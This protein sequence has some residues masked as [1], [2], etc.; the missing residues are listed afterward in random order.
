MFMLFSI[1][2]FVVIKET[3]NSNSSQAH[4]VHFSYVTWNTTIY[5]RYRLSSDQQLLPNWLMALM[6]RYVCLLSSNSW[7][8]RLNPKLPRRQTHDILTK[9]SQRRPSLLHRPGKVATKHTLTCSM[10]CVTF[11][12][13]HKTSQIITMSIFHSSVIEGDIKVDCEDEFPPK[14]YSFPTTPFEWA[15]NQKVHI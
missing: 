6:C 13:W 10:L 8:R 1:F 5:K 2:V 4:R 12:L 14:C 3:Q 9:S 15:V 11:V 7:S